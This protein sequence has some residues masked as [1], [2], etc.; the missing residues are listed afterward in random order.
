VPP[1][2]H[3]P[4]AGGDLLIEPACARVARQLCRALECMRLSSTGVGPNYSFEKRKE[5][6]TRLLRQRHPG[7]AINETYMVTERGLSAPRSLGC[8]GIVSKRRAG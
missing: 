4:P 5:R 2:L 3:F 8:E 7:I 1:L 6:L